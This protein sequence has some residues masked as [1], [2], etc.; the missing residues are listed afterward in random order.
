M[1]TL[2]KVI[3]GVAAVIGGYILISVVYGVIIY[4][5]FLDKIK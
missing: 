4:S 1:S 3:I 5:S 2:K